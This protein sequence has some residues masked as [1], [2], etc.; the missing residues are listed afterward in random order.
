MHSTYP[1]FPVV[2]HLAINDGTEEKYS[3]G[4]PKSTTFH[5]ILTPP[6]IDG[7]NNQVIY[8]N[9]TGY[10]VAF[11]GPDIVL[12]CEDFETNENRVKR[13][14]VCRLNNEIEKRKDDIKH[15]HSEIAKKNLEQKQM[16]E[17]QPANDDEL[18]E[19]RRS[20]KL[21][22]K[23]IEKH[24]DSITEI[25]EASEAYYLSCVE[26]LTTTIIKLVAGQQYQMPFGEIFTWIRLSNKIHEDP[27]TH[28]LTQ[29][30]YVVVK[31]LG[32]NV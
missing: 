18:L 6:P 27:S 22:H 14:A 12:T 5:H 28:V 21:S 24:E 31:E 2:G 7:K 20:I 16:F 30:K 23:L 13:K 29:K 17:D 1:D 9:S 3:D 10:D 25:V 32:V 4:T 15:L 8:H 19:I 26:K 11:D